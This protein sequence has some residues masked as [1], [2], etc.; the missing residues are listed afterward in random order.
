MFLATTALNQYWDKE[1]KNLFL[2]DWCIKDAQSIIDLEYEI[3]PYHWNNTDDMIDD[4]NYIYSTYFELIPQI[5]KHLNNLHN[6][7]FS[8]KYWSFLIG[9]WMFI[10]LNILYDRFISLTR[11][12]ETGYD[13]DTVISK[14]T[15]VPENFADFYQLIVHDEYNFYLYSDI[16]KNLDLG[17]NY[18]EEEVFL[19]KIDLTDKKTPNSNNISLHKLTRQKLR[20]FLKRI[21]SINNKN[22]FLRKILDFYKDDGKVQIVTSLMSIKDYRKFFAV[23]KHKI[24]LSFDINEIQIKKDNPLNYLLR[25]PLIIKSK[26]TPFISLAKKLL[27]GHM[28]KEYIENFNEWRRT[29]H[30]VK[31]AK[32]PSV[33]IL[34]SP[35]EFHS[36]IRFYCAEKMKNGSKII[37]MQHGGGFGVRPFNGASDIEIDLSDL[38]I[39]W[40]WDPLHPKGVKYYNTKTHWKKDYN[41]NKNGD[42]ILVGSGLRRYF[43]YGFSQPPSF[44]KSHLNFNQIFIN[45][46]P[47]E[48]FEKLIYRFHFNYGYNELDI[49]KKIFPDLR[50]STRDEVSYFY[51][52]LYNSR[53]V[54]ATTNYTTYLQSFILNH[55]T[56]IL[57]PQQF[58]K[59]SKNV[60]VW[61]DKLHKA[62]ILFYSPEECAEIL[63]N[64]INDIMSWWQ[65]Q[66]IQSARIEF[67]NAMCRESDSFGKELAELVQSQSF[68]R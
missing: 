35:F 6:V 48:I 22:S 60:Q 23:L 25:N 15:Y 59:I 20:I 17:I 21:F 19:S 34:R 24:N 57:W 37:A 64:N 53:L 54:I 66:E 1:Q 68:Y 30:S 47:P 61:F 45:N 51:E 43:T 33:V 12:S 8:D 40:G 55:P 11:A 7:N 63:K 39:T 31:W 44:N 27:I 14:D 62:G 4:M 13:L 36:S 28:P 65:S 67:C 46:L 49:I 10:F 52:L 2:G 41:Y 3:L 5:S 9:P 38:Y 26:D 32:S 58:N 42:I 50:T 56:L 16:I 18:K 29:I